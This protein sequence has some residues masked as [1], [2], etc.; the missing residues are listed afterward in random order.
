M[1]PQATGRQTAEPDSSD[2]RIILRAKVLVGLSWILAIS[3]GST[4]IYRFWQVHEQIETGRLRATAFVV[5]M[6]CVDLFGFLAY[7]SQFGDDRRLMN[8][9]AELYWP[10]LKTSLI[11]QA[12]FLILSALMLDMGQAFNLALLGWIAYWA[13]AAMIVVRRPESPTRAD[14]FAIRWG[15]LFSY[16]AVAIAG[17]IWWHHMGRL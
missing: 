3:L 11:V 15:Y 2:A 14:L 6:S 4:L 12:V 8:A 7:K 13:M 9:L 5:I 10:A 17:S 16:F 1:I